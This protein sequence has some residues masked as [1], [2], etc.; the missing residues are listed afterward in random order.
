MIQRFFKELFLPLKKRF[1]DCIPIKHIL[2][3]WRRFADKML[4]LGNLF[5]CPVKPTSL[6][7]NSLWTKPVETARLLDLTENLLRDDN[8]QL[9][10]ATTST[11][12]DP[13]I[14]FITCHFC[15]ILV[16]VICAA[17]KT[18]KQVLTLNQE[19]HRIQ[20]PILERLRL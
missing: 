3:C 20:V 19:I 6:T 1:S 9:E 11:F 2:L 18:Q 17:N 8:G 12:A 14:S 4:D 5:K 7:V 16:I 13:F 15:C 10:W